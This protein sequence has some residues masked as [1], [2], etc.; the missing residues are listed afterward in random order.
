MKKLTSK[1]KSVKEVPFGVPPLSTRFSLPEIEVIY[2]ALLFR[3]SVVA[4][5]GTKHKLHP[6]LRFRLRELADDLEEWSNYD[7]LLPFDPI[8]SGVIPY[9]LERC[10]FFVHDLDEIYPV[11]YLLAKLRLEDLY[12]VEIP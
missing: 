9:A 3:P 1:L 12:N 7:M 5:L 6:R 2:D 8:V 4:R 10:D 11:R